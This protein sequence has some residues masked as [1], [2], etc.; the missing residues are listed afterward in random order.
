MPNIKSPKYKY[1]LIFSIQIMIISIKDNA[2]CY[3][4]YTDLEL[5]YAI[6]QVIKL[7]KNLIFILTKINVIF[8]YKILNNKF[9][10]QTKL[11]FD[12]NIFF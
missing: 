11:K 6:N 7:P 10:L 2:F 9:L 1:L 8:I 3:D 5:D 4:I 12:T